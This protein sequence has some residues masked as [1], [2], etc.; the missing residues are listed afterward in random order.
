MSIFHRD[1]APEQPTEFTVLFGNE[2][3]TFTTDDFAEIERTTDKHEMQRL[4]DLGWLLLDESSGPGNGPPHTEFVMRASFFE[5]QAA[6]A[7]PVEEPP[8]D[9]TLYTVGSLKDG[10]TGRQ[11]S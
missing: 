2:F 5:G 7:V 3:V 11:P 4:V 9:V 10:A 6:K 8:G 1:K